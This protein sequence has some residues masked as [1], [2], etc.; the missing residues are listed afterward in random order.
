MAHG[1]FLADLTWQQAEP[2][3]TP[4]TVVVV[5][6]GAASKEHGP[7]LRLNND[8]VLADYFAHR[9]CEASEVLICPTLNYHYYP[10]F[11]D[12]PG[13]VTLSCATAAAL[14]AEV[15]ESLA[16]FGARRFYCLNT[17]FST[18][19]PLGMA[20]RRLVAKGC[21]FAF[22]ELP[23]L[24]DSV[25]TDLAEQA[26][27]THADEVETS[28]MLYISPDRVD[29]QSAVCDYQPGRGLSRTPVPGKAHSPS[30]VYGDATLATLEKGV[31]FVET[32]VAGI[33][34][35]VQK[36]RDAPLPATAGER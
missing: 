32:V 28:M 27:G 16:S 18:L 23:V 33:L 15:C 19:Q 7:H 35:G 11:T 30:G 20:R 25:T 21:L 8:Q 26:G 17:G 5:P 12:Y 9:L 10:A 31:Q 24:L 4:E 22:T 29:M 36:L 34:A 14:T 3:L 1:Y 2:L 13:S 6:L